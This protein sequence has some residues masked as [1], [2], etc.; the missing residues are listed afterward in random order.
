MREME[1]GIAI[2]AGGRLELKPGGSH[3][4]VTGLEAPLRPGEALKLM[5]RFEKSGERPLDV[6]VA[7]AAG[8]E[9]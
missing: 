5:L 4:M 3:V 7:P 6:K 8:P 2:P 1:A 9:N